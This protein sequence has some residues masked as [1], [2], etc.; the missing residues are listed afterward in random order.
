MIRIMNPILDSPPKKHPGLG[1]FIELTAGQ[2]ELR[3]E[4]NIPVPSPAIFGGTISLASDRFR[5]RFFKLCEQ[6]TRNGNTFID[7]T[8]VKE[9]PENSIML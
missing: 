2:N 1:K 4:V 9:K 3:N 5:Y 7:M 8:H 6:L